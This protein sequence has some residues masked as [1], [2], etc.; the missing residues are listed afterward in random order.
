M[1]VELIIFIFRN[2]NLLTILSMRDLLIETLIEKLIETIDQPHRANLATTSSNKQST[3][4]DNKYDNFKL[5]KCNSKL[6]QESTMEVL[7]RITEITTTTT[8]TTS[9]LLGPVLLIQTIKLNCRLSTHSFTHSYSLTH[10]RSFILTLM[11][12]HSRFSLFGI[13]DISE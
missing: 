3:S 9:E 8:S 5:R 2:N 10:S 11:L 12:T 6:C 4:N 13:K 7:K 1:I